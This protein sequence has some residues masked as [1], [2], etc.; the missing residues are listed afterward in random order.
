[1]M[2]VGQRSSRAQSTAKVA[3]RTYSFNGI[4]ATVARRLQSY[5]GSQ[6][7]AVLQDGSLAMVAR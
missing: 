4:K 6:A 1:M 5:D 2:N 7:T 3:R